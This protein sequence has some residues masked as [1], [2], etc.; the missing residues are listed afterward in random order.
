MPSK[1]KKNTKLTK[2]TVS[3]QD[4]ELVEETTQAP[5]LEPVQESVQ[6]PVQEP[7][8]EQTGGAVEGGNVTQPET[9]TSAPKKAAPK[10]AVAKAKGKPKVETQKGSKGKGKGE[11]KVKAE[12]E[13]KGGQKTEGKT[14]TSKKPPIDVENE[15]EDDGRENDSE[16]KIRSFKVKLP[17]KEE[18]EGR[19]TGLTPYQAA[20][21]ALSKYFRENAN[22]M[23][24][25]TFSICE[26]TRKSKKTTYTYVGRRQK[27]EVPVTYT[28]QDGRVIEKNFKN[29]LKKVKKADMAP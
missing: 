2:T 23:T 6:E 25:I 12:T 21:K 15:H 14:R 26:S 20:N 7:V 13:L 4:Q 5:V 8:Q 19:F 1:T 24:E 10:K 27:L 11:K 9:S 17:N 29:S 22:P 28:I 16:R 3:E 18:F